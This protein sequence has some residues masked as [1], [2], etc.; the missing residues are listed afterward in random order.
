MMH[1]KLFER[2]W[3]K[4]TLQS[5]EISRERYNWVLITPKPNEFEHKNNV[6]GFEPIILLQ[7]S[8]YTNLKD[9]CDK[10]FEILITNGG[11][12]NLDL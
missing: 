2:V 3:A 1:L 10:N 4:I 9:W 6:R 12:D 7:S 8:T 11:G 5:T